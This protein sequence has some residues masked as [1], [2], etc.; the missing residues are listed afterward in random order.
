MSWF[1]NMKLNTKFNII[2]S[3]LLICLFFMAGLLTYRDQRTMIL[4]VAL[5]HARGI[6]RQIIETRNYMAGAVR[7]EPETNYAL[8]PEAVATGVAKR[9]TTGSPY[10]VRQIS[11]RFRN[12][13]NRPDD[14]EAIQLR[15]F[16]E[17]LADESHQMTTEKG[18]KVFRFMRKM[19]A[20]GSCLRCHGAYE[21][22]PRFV[23]ERFPPGHSSYNYK[24]GEVIGAVSVSIP[25]VDLYRDIGT[26]LGHE[27][28][29]RVGILMLV[30][31]GMGL[32][33]R[34]FIINP[35]RLASATMGRV[36]ET[37]D[38][39]ERIPAKASKDEIGELIAGFNEMMEELDRANLQR[40]ESEDRYRNLI[41]AAQAAIVTF[42]AN[43]KIVISN[44]LAE[45]FFGLPRQELLG[46]TIFDLLENGETLRQ[47]IA[48]VSNL[49]NGTWMGEASHDR[50]CDV[51]GRSTDV[52]VTLILA[53]KTEQ[54]PMFT[55]IL[56][57]N[58]S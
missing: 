27:L 55:V 44:H 8:V 39:S 32:M 43:G 7:N 30:F 51:S 17:K 20:E 35:I 9:L 26:N 29:S 3:S 52:K 25:L 18:E 1:R 40:Q 36:T 22:A 42:L 13:N 49:D 2:L 47:R 16:A 56:R 12:P 5:E 46:K 37:G 38:L 50:I 14:Y 11:L 21:E 54:A 31:V 6:A 10:Y 48:E 45:S 58:R 57:E 15:G 33:I 23:Q 28:L 53:S 19:I 41:E 24:I 34:R 4:N